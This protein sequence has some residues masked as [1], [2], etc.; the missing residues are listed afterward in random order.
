MLA[1]ATKGEDGNAA[2]WRP[3]DEYASEVLFDVIS[4]RSALSGPGNDGQRFAHLQSII[5]TDAGREEFG[6]GMTT[7]WWRIVDEPDAFPP[8]LWQLFLQSILTALE[9]KVPAGLRG[10]DMEEAHYRRGYATVATEVGGGQPRGETVR[11][12]RA[13]RSGACKSESSSATRDRQMARSHRLLHRLRH[14]IAVLAKVANCVPA[15]TPLVAKCYGSRP[16]DV[17]FR[18]DSG[19]TRTITCSSGVQQRD[20]MEPAMFCL[21]LRPGLKRFQEEF[22]GEGIE[23]FAYM[24][25]VSLGLVGATANT[26]RVFLC[27]PPARVRSH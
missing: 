11:G 16:A 2:Q 25:D 5:H 23:A 15:L 12:R 22:E 14:R 9:G 17:F 7:S 8:E 13:R 27:L 21:A 10:H 20:P 6:R 1:N 4:S 3:D 18:M 19:E 26:V 24:G